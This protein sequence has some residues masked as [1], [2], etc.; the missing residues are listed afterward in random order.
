MARKA[1]LSAHIDEKK[2]K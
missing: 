1:T 2:P